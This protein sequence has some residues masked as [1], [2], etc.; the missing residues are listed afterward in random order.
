MSR[1]VCNLLAC[2]GDTFLGTTP[3]PQ[4][5]RERTAK[6]D[7]AHVKRVCSGKDH[8]DRKETGCRLRGRTCVR[9]T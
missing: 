8:V 4:T 2:D 9:H 1:D 6:L 7:L 5:T 3:R